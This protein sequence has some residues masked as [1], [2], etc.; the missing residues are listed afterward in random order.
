MQYIS[1]EHQRAIGER[2]KVASMIV[3]A[4]CVS[5]GVLMIIGSLVNPPDTLPYSERLNSIIPAV[6][7]VMAM[8]VIV[9]RRIWMTA[10]I[11]RVAARTG[12]SAT[13]NRLLQ[14][15]VVCAALSELV[16]IVGFM[17]Y[18]LTGNYRYSLILCTVSLLLLL[19][20]AFPRRGE[21]E[22][23]VAAAAKAQA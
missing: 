19:Y 4:F 5:V 14:M 22:R 23:A 15:T 16:A 18:L 7:I 9:L 20:T 1:V 12:V 10:M 3:L 13:L 2:F 11:M 17:F 8:G 21:W 6:V